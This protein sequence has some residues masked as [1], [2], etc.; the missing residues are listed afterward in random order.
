MYG[1]RQTMRWLDCAHEQRLASSQGAHVSAFIASH[2]WAVAVAGS[3]RLRGPA[4]T[5]V[6]GRWDRER[7]AAST[8]SA[9]VKKRSPQAMTRTPPSA[10]TSKTQHSARK[11]GVAR[12]SCKYL[13]ATAGKQE[14][15]AS[16]PINQKYVIAITPSLPWRAAMLSQQL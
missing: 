15:E 12:D 16:Q 13:R 9:R 6:D 8:R 11:R 5:I 3:S 10:I 2:A 4:L 7:A 14:R 1:L